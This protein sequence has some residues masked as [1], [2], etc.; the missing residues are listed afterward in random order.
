MT[1]T[2]PSKKQIGLPPGLGRVDRLG[3]PSQNNSLDK[4]VV[5]V[6]RV[7]AGEETHMDDPD[8]TTVTLEVDEDI[9]SDEA[10]E[11]AADTEKNPV[12][13]IVSVPVEMPFCC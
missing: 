7:G 13:T 11:A 1:E 4:L 8:K 6:L 9:L 10:L 5:T 12:A 2:I 3:R